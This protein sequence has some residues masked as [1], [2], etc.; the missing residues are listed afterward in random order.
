MRAG[1]SGG[2]VVAAAAAA[3]CAL[4]WG[5]GGACAAAGD[6]GIDVDTPGGLA[7]VALYVA[8][9]GT[10]LV[11][12]TLNLGYAAY[13]QRAPVELRVTG[14]VAAA[15]EVAVGVGTLVVASESSPGRVLG[16]VPFVA[17]ALSV[18]AAWWGG[19]AGEASRF[20]VVPLASDGRWGL[21]VG[22]VL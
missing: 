11:S 3:A 12:S 20:A 19:R 1:R 4:V 16:V 14:Y 18:G 22:G 21:V 15:V 7:L 10:A 9:L 13:D 6:G 17:A 5:S 2:R 8:P